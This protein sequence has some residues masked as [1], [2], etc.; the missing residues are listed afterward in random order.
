MLLLILIGLITSRVILRSLGVEDYGVYNAVGG[1]VVLFTLLSNSIAQAIGRFITFE[2]GRGG[3]R[4]KEIFAASVWVQAG[5]AVILALLVNTIGLWFLFNKMNIPPARMDAAVVVLELSLITLIINLFAVPYNATVIAH[6]R[7]GAFAGISILEA[8]L[9]LSV[10]LVIWLWPGDKLVVYAILMTAVALIV[11]MSYAL[12]CRCHFEE[13]R[14]RKKL[15]EKALV[16][17]LAGFAG[18]NFIG[19]SAFVINTQGI[20]LLVNVFFG[21]TLNAARGVATQVEGII[22]QFASN[23]LTALNPQITKSFAEGNTDY[24]FEL[25]IKGARYTWLILLLFAVPFI[26]EADMILQLWLGKTAVPESAALFTKLV[27]VGIMVDMV[28]NSLL[29][30]ELAGG[31]IRDYYLITGAISYLAL[32]VSWMLFSMAGAP[33]WTPY[34]VFIGTYFLVDVAKLL[35]L[36]RQMDFPVG[37]FLVETALKC[38]SV[39]IIATGLTWLCRHLIAGGWIR[40]LVVLAVSTVSI[41]LS[42]WCLAMT[43]GERSFVLSKLRRYD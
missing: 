3:A 5:I 31:K 37:R 14:G 28:C 4:L 13:S 10:A 32:P 29:T 17:E 9:K 40:L 8:A 26:F 20:N 2:M 22:K 30:L 42:T 36:K 23:F 39:T 34:A 27:I 38:G 15:P 18:W 25:V 21:V 35:I 19:S 1:V 43:A 12:F 7:M 41:L 11:R 33:A 6:E 16:K 24:S